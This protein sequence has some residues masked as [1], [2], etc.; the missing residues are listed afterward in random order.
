VT[1]HHHQAAIKA[2]TKR[3]Y[4]GEHVNAVWRM[5]GEITDAGQAARNEIIAAIITAAH[6]HL[7]EG[8]RERLRAQLDAE[9]IDDA[10]FECRLRTIMRRDP[11][12][13]ERWID[14]RNRVNGHANWLLATRSANTPE[15]SPR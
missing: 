12:L 3:V 15:E 7:A 1:D 4:A 5:A 14:Q 8:E 11:Q 9:F 6:P 10:Q 13:L 2:A